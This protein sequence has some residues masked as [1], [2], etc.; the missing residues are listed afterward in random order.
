MDT[1]FSLHL[2]PSTKL[3]AARDNTAVYEVFAR[4]YLAWTTS[5]RHEPQ[6]EIAQFT[7]Y[8]NEPKNFMLTVAEGKKWPQTFVING[9]YIAIEM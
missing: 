4:L 7:T 6:L 1:N 8:D 2:G 9:C 3:S 5:R